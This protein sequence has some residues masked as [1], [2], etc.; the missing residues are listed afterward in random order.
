MK[1]TIYRGTREIGGNCVE[2]ASGATRLVLDLGLPLEA[3]GGETQDLTSRRRPDLAVLRR[4]G[5]LPKVPGVFGDEPRASG[6]LLSHAHADHAGLLAV[7]D[8]AIPIF[9]S[10]GT[11]GMLKAGSIFVSWPQ[12]DESRHVILEP[13]K[14]VEI[15]TFRVTP[16]S[17][18]H[19]AYD[20][21][22]FLIEADGK[23]LLYSGDLRLHG[24]KPGMARALIEAVRS[25][26]VDVLVMEGT[27]FT[28]PRRGF[29][30]EKS[31]EQH[32]VGRLRTAP[33]LGL[34]IFSPQHVD[35]LVTF[36]KAALRSGRTLVLDL[37][38]ACVMHLAHSQHPSIPSPSSAESVRV[39]YPKFA[40]NKPLEYR[41]R[42]EKKRIVLDEIRAFPKDF[43]MLFR[44]SM[45]EPDFG[46]ELPPSTHAFYSMWSGY[47][48]KSEWQKLRAHVLSGGGSFEE[49]HTSGHI[50]HDD[51]VRFVKA[52]QPK[53][54]VPIHT[55]KGEAFVEHFPNTLLLSDR[56]PYTL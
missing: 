26:R 39:F 50:F 16:F 52:V 51:I 14:V 44:P 32:L 20:S 8:P 1:L 49:F 47:L 43:L 56:Q 15:G 41:E 24:R 36:F 33:G 4:K 42:F 45:L 40:A 27:H 7:S 23:R 18:D 30:D 22:A 38:G 55:T 25:P 13:R 2:V 3:P 37:Y 11:Q 46:G 5:V 53:N 48:E 17:V 19:S 28:A 9:L 54:V 21:L 12:L 6:I 34:A 10:R 29:A 35:R 31:L